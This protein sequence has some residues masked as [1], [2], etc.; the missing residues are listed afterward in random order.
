MITDAHV[1]DINNFNLFQVERELGVLSGRPLDW[2]SFLLTLSNVHIGH[3]DSHQNGAGQHMCTTFTDT[4]KQCCKGDNGE[5]PLVRKLKTSKITM[6]WLGRSLVRT[7]RCETQVGMEQHLEEA[8]VEIMTWPMSLESQ[9]SSTR[10][11][12]ADITG[13]VERCCFNVDGHRY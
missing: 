7:I 4:G 2:F 12:E 9:F 13:S 3:Q 6:F 10:H 1:V 8:E 5:K 11:R